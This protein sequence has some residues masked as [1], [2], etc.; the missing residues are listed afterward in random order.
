VRRRL[1]LD[2]GDLLVIDVDD[3]EDTFVVRKATDV[4]RGFCGYLSAVEPHRDLAAELIA[5]RQLEAEREDAEED[6]HAVGGSQAGTAG[7]R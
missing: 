5:E 2:P 4:A 3:D 7:R 6:A 1:D